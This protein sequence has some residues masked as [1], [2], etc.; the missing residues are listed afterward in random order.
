M[1]ALLA[2][3]LIQSGMQNVLRTMVRRRRVSGWIG[4]HDPMQRAA[5]ESGR[6]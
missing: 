1:R 5:P 2:P 4:Q 3:V 6:S